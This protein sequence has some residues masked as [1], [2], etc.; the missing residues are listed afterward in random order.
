[1][2]RKK[3]KSNQISTLYLLIVAVCIVAIVGVYLLSPSITGRVGSA[4]LEELRAPG[5]IELPRRVVV[6]PVCGNGIVE[7]GEQCDDGNTQ[8]G[9]GCSSTCQN[10]A[11]ENVFS[12]TFGGEYTNYAYSARQTAD[13]GYI[14]SGEKML[15]TPGLTDAWLVKTD[16]DGNQQWSRTFGGDDRDFGFSAQQ[17]SD[18]GYIMGGTTILG[19]YTANMLLVKT[20]SNGNQQWSRTFGDNHLAYGTTT[21][22]TSDGGYIIVGW[23]IDDPSQPEGG[24]SDVLLVKTDSNGNQQWNKTF[25]GNE[26][27]GGISAQQTS[28]GGYIIAGS[29]QSFGSGSYDVWLIKT[30]SSGYEQWS[31]TF[32]GVRLDEPH[33][34]QIT[35]DGGYIIIGYTASFSGV[36]GDYDFWLIK[37]DS[38]GTTCS[39][40]ATGECS[41]SS[42]KF[43]KIFGG[44]EW[45]E[46]FSVQQTRDGGYIVT[47]RTGSF[48]AG[49]GD[50]WLIKTDAFGNEPDDY[51]IVCSDDLTILNQDIEIVYGYIPEYDDYIDLE[52]A[53][54]AD[55]E[56]FG[57]SVNDVRMDD[58][59]LYDGDIILFENTLIRIDHVDYILDGAEIIG[60]EV[61]YSYRTPALWVEMED[62]NA[63]Q[64]TT[65]LQGTY[66]IK[67][68]NGD[69]TTNLGGYGW[70]GNCPAGSNNLWYVVNANSDDSDDWQLWIDRDQDSVLEFCTECNCLGEFEINVTTEECTDSDGGKYVHVAGSTCDSGGCESDYCVYN[71]ERVFEYYCTGDVKRKKPYDCA[72]GCSDGACIGTTPSSCS[73]PDN[74]NENFIQSLYTRTTVTTNIGESLTD[75][76]LENNSPTVREYRCDDLNQIA[77]TNYICPNG[78]SNGACVDQATHTECVGLSCATLDG[79]GVDECINH[80]DCNLNSTVVCGNYILEGSEEC[81]RGNPNGSLCDWNESTPEGPCNQVACFCSDNY[82]IRNVCFQDMCLPVAGI[83]GDECQT[84]SDCLAGNFTHTACFDTAC[85]I[86]SWSGIDTCSTDADCGGTAITV[87][88]PSQTVNPGGTATIVVNINNIVDLFSYEMTVYF[89]EEVLDLSSISQGSFLGGQF[90]YAAPEPGRI[91]QIAEFRQ[92]VQPG[93]SGSGDL[94]SIAF[95]GE[96]IGT[97]SITITDVSFYNSNQEPVEPGEIG[98]ATI[99][100]QEGALGCSNNLAICDLDGDKNIGLRDILV[101]IPHWGKNQGEPDWDPNMDLNKDGNVGLRDVM[102]FMD[103]DVWGKY[104]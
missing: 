1:M 95:V 99:T 31:R 48:G 82:P 37:T 73:D 18:G 45:D 53:V 81:E 74:T 42:E 57:V 87:T 33:S 32:G 93:V 40:A 29:T 34:V 26:S 65:P 49:G 10:V 70:S 91:R 56:M 79:A 41:E 46:G 52:R 15:S 69:V 66:T 20:D 55:V 62:E 54:S 67:T 76:C 47:G 97:S 11:C 19:F 27:D 5:A 43:V 89:N 100:V 21:Q 12:K 83:G 28:D 60:A 96:T 51:P 59:P 98:G 92:A 38:N 8:D 17:T 3:S 16:S 30:D 101:L 64:F 90:L 24:Q 4:T 7:S 44:S 77:W 68:V 58:G 103:R 22:Q 9:D 50:A 35:S 71:N 84:P 39:Y 94:F 102:E 80:E 2:A 61:E 85:L 86:V 13:E 78:C 23:I 14:I 63:C 25:G 104:Y 72:F 88:P 36:S 6:T 75:T